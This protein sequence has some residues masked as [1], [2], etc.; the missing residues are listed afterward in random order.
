MVSVNRFSFTK[1]TFFFGNCNNYCSKLVK[2]T[3]SEGKKEWGSSTLNQ[4][5]YCYVFRFIIIFKY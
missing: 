2:E 3:I 1:L 4:T 5:F